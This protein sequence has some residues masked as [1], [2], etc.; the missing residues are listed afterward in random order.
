MKL[1]L[2]LERTSIKNKIKGMEQQIFIREIVAH[3]NLRQ[4]KGN[5]PT[6]IYMVV[7]VGKKQLKFPIGCK[8][9]PSQWNKKTERAFISPMLSELDNRNNF[10]VNSKISDYLFGF[11]EV[12]NYICNEPERALELENILN[13]KLKKGNTSRMGK[14]ENAILWLFHD[15]EKAVMKDGSRADYEQQ[16]KDFEKFC[17]DTNRIPLQWEDITYNLLMEYQEWLM[18]TPVRKK[19]KRDDRTIGNKISK[20]IT[21]LKHAE[22]AGKIDSYQSRIHLYEKPKTSYQSQDNTFALSEDE[23]NSLY[24]LNLSG[25][26]ERARDL[27]VFQLWSGQRFSDLA[28][29][30]NGIIDRDNLKIKIVQ[31]KETAP[32]TIPIFPIALEIL[33][34]YNWD[35]PL[36]T[37]A[38]LNKLIKEVAV[39]AKLTREH[40]KTKQHRGNV[41]TTKHLICDNIASHCARRSFITL[42]MR[43]RLLTKEQIMNISGHKTESAFKRYVKLMSDEVADEALKIFYGEEQPQRPQQTMQSV[44][45]EADTQNQFHNLYKESIRETIEAENRLK[46]QEKK[47]NLLSQMLRI[48]EQQ[49]HISQDRYNELRQAALQGNYEEYVEALSEND[50]VGKVLDYYN[51]P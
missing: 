32:I 11:R 4:P 18:A 6:P 25:D 14:K 35:L 45:G 19:G 3:F 1:K 22:R 48:E 28:N 27:F 24:R 29:I 40:Y 7:R 33:E 9:Y 39:R 21:R 34:K 2:A 46:E 47:I 31:D 10:I 49:A 30:Y 8:I 42:M 15:L 26:L 37:M 13:N 43:K 44:S 12:L 50:E 38:K 5:K 16:I 20:L 23:I 36:M 51:E 41:S 17:K